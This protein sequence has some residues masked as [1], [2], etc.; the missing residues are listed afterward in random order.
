MTSSAIKRLNKELVALAKDTPPGLSAAPCGENLSQWQGLIFG[1]EGTP[2]EGGIFELSMTFP[3]NYPFSPPRIRFLNDVFHPNVGRD[4]LICLDIL[5]SKWSPCMEIRTV[6]MSIQSLL[7]SPD[8]HRNPSGAANNEAESLF[9]SDRNAYNQRIRKLVQ[10]Q[11]EKYEEE[12][13]AGSS[14]CD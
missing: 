1:P 6:L 14:F 2:Y 10:L 5:G 12:T 13:R 9:V 8:L 4:G 7:V 3:E 11:I